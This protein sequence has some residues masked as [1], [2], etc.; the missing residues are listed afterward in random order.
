MA[1]KITP[2]TGSIGASVEGVRLDELDDASFAAIHEAFLEHLMLVFRDQHIKPATHVEFARRWGDPVVT[3]MLTPLDGQPEIVQITNIPKETSATEAWHYDAPFTEVPPKI[4]ILAGV[5]IP[6]GG[7][8]MWS[9]QYQAFERLSPDMQVWLTGLKVRFR[10]SKLGKMLSVDE[11]DIPEAV[12]PLVRTHPETGRKALYI[13]HTE[14]LL[15]VEGW[16]RE[17]SLPLLEYLY[18]HSIGPDNLY[19]HMWREG[20][21]VMWDNRCTMHYAVHDYG[22]QDRALNRVTLKGEVPV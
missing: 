10:G 8:T 3:A 14:N 20:D 15:R 5:T 4:S 6:H 21:V 7:D 16:T 19:R 13:T 11:Q 12:H 9:N 2:L 1:L 22:N 18:N 17:E